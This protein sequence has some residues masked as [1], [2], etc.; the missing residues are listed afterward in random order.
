[1]LVKCVCIAEM[2]VIAAMLLAIAVFVVKGIR[3]LVRDLKNH[4]L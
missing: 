4:T 3:D 1:M 2:T